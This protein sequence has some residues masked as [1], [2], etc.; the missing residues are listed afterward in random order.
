MPDVTHSLMRCRIHRGSKEVG[1]SCI[2]L[3]SAGKRL[4]LDLGRPLA[5]ST[6]EELPLPD[7]E[8][9]DGTGALECVV[10][11][12]GH[13]D[14]YGLA[15]GLRPGV[16]LFI[17]EATER[18]LS[19]AL[20]FSPSGADFAPAGHL[21]DRVPIRLGPFT[22]TPYAVDHSAFDA[23]A[24]LVE[25]SG[26]RLFY[27][28][29]VRGHGRKKTF[30]ALLADPPKGIHVTLLEGTHVTAGPQPGRDVLS[31]SELED[32]C[33]EVMGATAGMVLAAY[34][35][36]NI[37]RLVTLYRAA[38]RSGRLLV[39]DLY[40]ATLAAATGRSTIPQ[41]DW[42]G[43]RVFVPLSQRIKVK[44]SG[45]F[46][47]TAAVRSHRVYEEDL[48][49]MKSQLVLTFRG[50]MTGDL[51]RAACVAGATCIWSM[52]AGYLEQPSSE[53]LLTWLTDRGIPVHRLHSSGHAPVRDLQRLATSLGG[54]IVPMHTNAPERFPAL[55]EN[56]EPHPDGEWWTV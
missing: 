39:L 12:H 44:A 45:E 13:A 27:S 49:A 9:I 16:R 51:D 41:A 50:S 33:A 34:S 20:F 54:R 31:E 30:E 48:A 24:L 46:H 7:I 32:R 21:H 42:D 40:G 14:H 35:A 37:D 47:R 26:R 22:V 15:V 38:K 1:G 6:L 10:I 28:A 52:W 36:Q 55:F 29:D 18:I 11:S 23:F 19:E 4:V 56:V 5:A 53:R 17:G 3:E 8:G 43:V 2:E 25:A